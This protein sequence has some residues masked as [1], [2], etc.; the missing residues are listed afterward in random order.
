VR[1]EECVEAYMHAREMT[2]NLEATSLAC[3]S[4]R[5]VFELKSA[6]VD[7]AVVDQS[8]TQALALTAAAVEV[9]VINDSIPSSEVRRG[10][11]KNKSN[12]SPLQ[13][14]EG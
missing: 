2:R 5:S 12:V 1:A 8:W 9:N 11:R 4:V 7:D 10:G 6:K 3:A 14:S 13:G